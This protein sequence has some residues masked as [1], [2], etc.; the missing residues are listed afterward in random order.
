[1]KRILAQKPWPKQIEIE[2][3]IF[4]GKSKRT[5]ISGCVGSTKTYALAMCALVWLM[6]YKPSR[7]LSLAPSFRQVDVNLWG[8]MR[9]LWNAARENGTPVGEECDIFR[10]PKIQFHDPRTGKPVPEWYYEGFS[11]DEPGNVHGV[12]GKNDLVILDDAQGISPALF[13]ELENMTAGGNNR[14]V[15]A[16]NKMVLQGPTYECNHREAKAWNHVSVCYADLV[17]ARAAGYVLDGALDADAE[18]RWR[19][20]Y[21]VAS[22]FYRTK[23]L[24]QYPKQE[25][26]TL[27]PLEWIELAYDR[28]VV[29][30]GPLVIGGDVGAQGDDASALAP[31]RGR[32]IFAVEEWHEPD[33]MVTTG[34]FLKP[35]RDEESH[36]DGKAAVSKAFA[37]V[38][39]IGIG[40]GVV[41]RMSEQTQA[42]AGHRASCSG[43]GERIKVESV[44]GSESAVGRVMDAG[45]I[46]HAKDIYRNKRAQVWWALR[47]ALNPANSD[48]I[49]LTRDDDLTAQ[50]SCIRWRLGSDGRIEVEPKISGTGDMGNWGIKNRLGFSPNK[51][52]AVAYANWGMT[53][54]THGEFSISSARGEDETL[55]AQADPASSRYATSA[56]SVEMDGVDGG[57]DGV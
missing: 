23:V 44:D 51:A 38:D 16:Y 13:D 20:K 32:R 3:A 41:N 48:L 55:T 28:K 34:K 14:L 43:C 11:T 33:L 29:E 31:A 57:L 52:D 18:E 36:E 35:M 39:G 53:R 54:F 42:L 15:I 30:T 26:D 27:I 25:K 24:N 37:F 5:E 40:A 45:V 46:K 9:K 50:L 47:E 6:A 8:Y 2:A 19:K 17:K 1:M 49:A 56:L 7:V 22:N 4:D 21:G 10:V 12:H